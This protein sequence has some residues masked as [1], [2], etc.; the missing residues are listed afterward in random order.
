MGWSDLG[1]SAIVD[2]V[3]HAVRAR[4][5]GAE[6]FGLTLNPADTTLKHGIDAYT[7]AAYSLPFYPVL[8][9]GDLASGESAAGASGRASRVVSAV[10]SALKRTPIHGALRTW[11]VVPF[12]FRREPAHLA[13]SRERLRGASAV[14]IAGGG[15]LDATWGGL[16]GHPYVLWRWGRLAREM[17]AR[18]IFASVGTGSLPGLSRHLVLRALALAD[19]RSFRDERSREL[20]RADLTRTDPVVPD[21]AYAMPVRRTPAPNRDRVVVGISP[22]NYRLPTR[23][24]KPDAERYR[25]HIRTFAELAARVL[26]DGHEVVVFATDDDGPAIDDTM[27]AIAELAPNATDRLRSAPTPT[28]DSLVELIGSLDAVVV[29]RLH[30]VLLSHLTHRPVM[31]VAHE[32][33]VRT[34]M[35]EVG[36]SRYCFDIL[37]FDPNAGYERLREL[38]AERQVLTSQIMETVERN[39]QR[40]LAQYDVLFG[41]VR[42]G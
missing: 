6:I 38:L 15:Q 31:A 4:M 21:L 36:H 24:P 41:P 29:A 35:D 9:P 18:F 13:L 34:L 17:G 2:S 10:R 33:K 20:L 39:R 26:A 3:I 27:K 28:V 11:A 7:C 22:M 25:R 37:D 23:W 30:G 19:Y 16:L 5:P 12:R 42:A 32:R 14:V 8:E 1:N 40:V